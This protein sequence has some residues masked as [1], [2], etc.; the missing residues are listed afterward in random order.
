VRL[1]ESLHRCRTW[2]SCLT[3]GANHLAYWRRRTRRYGRRAVLNL[4]HTEDE[5]EAVTRRQKEEIFPY[6]SRML[7][8]DERLLLDFG[9]GC[10]RFTPDLADMI[11]GRSIGI[12]PVETLIKMAPP[13]NNVEYR[14]FKPSALPFPDCHFDV[15]W[16]CLVLGGLK[17]GTLVE[18]V[19]DIRRV[20]RPDGLLFLIE[21]TSQKKDVGH[22]HYRSS[23]EYQQLFPFVNL[24]HLNDYPDM[25]ERISILAGR[26]F[27]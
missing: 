19:K 2:L 25:D 12:D 7:R 24:H 22:W 27:V 15:V 18:V 17:D 14:V 1:A 16:I 13:G 26:K 11:G 5:F 3:D 6:F 10:G 4:G 9:C 21:N 23:D 20:L 8:G